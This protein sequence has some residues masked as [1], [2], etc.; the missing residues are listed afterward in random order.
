MQPILAS[1][2]EIDIM[3]YKG[4]Q[5]TTVYGTLHYPGNSGNGNGSSTT[6]ALHQHFIFIN[7]LSPCKNLC[8]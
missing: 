7:N 8:G 2:C 3:E 5:P 4:S 1:F 6:V